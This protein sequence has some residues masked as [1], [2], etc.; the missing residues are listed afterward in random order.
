MRFILPTGQ[1]VTIDDVDA[2]KLD[3][4]GWTIE[5]REH[6]LYVVG[7]RGPRVARERVYLHRIIMAAKPGELID[8]RDRDG[9]NNRRSNLRRSTKSGNAANTAKRGGGVS[10][11]KGVGWDSRRKA[12]RARIMV[13]CHDYHLG[14]FDSEAAAA[15]AYD[16]A[17]LSHFGEHAVLNAARD[18]GLAKARA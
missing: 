13:D 6:T 15:A 18:E 8:H 12:W 14:Y 9:L 5:R 16:R 11:Y 4:Y 2:P 1:V 10:R 3:G 17:A 7:E